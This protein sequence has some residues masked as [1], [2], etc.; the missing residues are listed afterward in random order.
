[1]Y[2]CFPP[3]PNGVGV[4]DG[5]VVVMWQISIKLTILIGQGYHKVKILLGLRQGW[6]QGLVSMNDSSIQN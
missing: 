4:R 2:E 3:L 1:M 6:L 5:A